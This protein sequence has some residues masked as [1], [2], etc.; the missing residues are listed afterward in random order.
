MM[1][2]STYFPILL[3]SIV[4]FFSAHL[5]ADPPLYQHNLDIDREI[6]SQAERAFKNN[7]IKNYEALSKQY[8]RSIKS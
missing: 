3:F 5:L 7:D 1:Q 4:C 2:K 8:C 6:F